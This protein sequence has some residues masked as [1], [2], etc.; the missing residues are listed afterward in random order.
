MAKQHESSP[1]RSGSRAKK[2]G[3]KSVGVPGRVTPNLIQRAQTDPQSLSPADV[4]Q[5]QRTIGMKAT[6]RLT[7]RGSAPAKPLS[8]V[9]PNRPP[10]V[11]R[12]VVWGKLGGEEM[13]VGVESKAYVPAGELKVETKEPTASLFPSQAKGKSGEYDQLSVKSLS[14]VGSLK[15]AKTGDFA[16][17]NVK[18]PK[19]FFASDKKLEEANKHLIATHSAYELQTQGA[20]IKI[21]ENPLLQTLP[22][23]RVTDTEGLKTTSLHRCNEM[24][25]RV[26]G[27]HYQQ[28][29]TR[30]FT[31]GKVEDSNLENLQK[32]ILSE[33]F[34]DPSFVKAYGS[35]DEKERLALSAAT[36]INEFANPEIGEAFQI[37][38]LGE[39]TAEGGEWN[40]HWAGVVAKSASDYVTLENYN[41]NDKVDYGGKGEDKDTHWFFQMYGKETLAQTFY[42]R[43]TGP[44]FKTPITLTNFKNHSKQVEQ[45]SRMKHIPLSE[46]ETVAKALQE[47]LGISS[48]EVDKLV[49]EKAMQKDEEVMGAMEYLLLTE[50]AFDKKLK[51]YL[52]KYVL[53]PLEKM[54]ETIKLLKEAGLSKESGASTLGDAIKEFSTGIGLGSYKYS[55]EKWLKWGNKN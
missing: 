17:E 14:N 42:Q 25:S 33:L 22:R 21:N 34:K 6:G 10:A 11:Q 51:T 4:I 28:G 46:P 36:G 8:P 7:G 52:T 19:A 23:N 38:S 9:M 29:A 50:D 5:L 37:K 1:K 47:I 27:L 30:K 24:A 49:K 15:I 41:R 40:Y 53:L 2:S 48:E 43:Q 31:E 13:D 55:E 44:N 3:Q 32:Q 39:Q 26:M 20:S 35:L 45:D 12:Y 54:V 16:I 18:E